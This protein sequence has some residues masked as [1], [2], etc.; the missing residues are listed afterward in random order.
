MTHTAES[1]I[2]ASPKFVKIAATEALELIAQT[3][4]QSFNTAKSALEAGSESV[5]NQVSKLVY[6]AAQELADQLNT[7][8]A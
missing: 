5:T 8:A 7:E 2:T 4:G 6:K 1:I 3:N